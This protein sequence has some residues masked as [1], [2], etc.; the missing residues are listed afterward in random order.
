M[1]IC[2]TCGD[3]ELFYV[4]ACG[5][6]AIGESQ[7]LLYSGD[8]LTEIDSEIQT[9]DEAFDVLDAAKEQG[10]PEEVIRAQDNL[11][12][13]LDTYIK[14]GTLLP[15]KHLVQA[16]SITRRR[17]TRIRSDKMRNHWRKIPIEP[18]LRN[19]TQ[20]GQ[21]NRSGLRTAFG[22]VARKLRD[23]ISGDGI[24]FNNQVLK[25]DVAADFSDVLEADWLKWVDAVN[26]SMTYAYSDQNHDFS[27][28][29]QLLRAYAGFGVKLG[30]NPIKGTYGLSANAEAKAV[31]GEAAAV[32]EGYLPHRDGWQAMIEYGASDSSKEGRQEALD[33][34][35]FRFRIKLTANAMLG[36]SIYATAGL[37]FKPLPGTGNI[38]AQ[39]A[40]A[41][42]KGEISVG[43]FAGVE[44]GGSATG[45]LD[46][47]NPGWTEEGAVKMGPE[48]SPL[49]EIG[50]ALFG[51]AGAGFDANFKISFEG[52]RFMFRFQAQLVIGIGAKGKLNGVVGFSDILE[53]IMYVYQQLKD[54]DFSYLEFMD[55]SAFTALIGVNLYIIEHGIDAAI[56]LGNGLGFAASSAL[57][58]FNRANAAEDYATTI[59]SRPAAM[60]FA[61]PEAKGAILYKLSETYLFSFEERQEAAILTVVGTVQ[62]QREWS[63]IVER[64]SQGGR[65]TSA[66]AGLAR[67]RYILDGGSARS[68]ET[69][70][71]AIGSLPSNTMYAGT[72]VNVRNLA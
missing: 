42:G 33:F 61:S 11:A 63:L 60:I 49:L 57:A 72:P 71:R 58:P 2:A 5:D 65:K 48:W 26:D 25:G 27:A 30:H 67:L 47:K 50:G 3:F 20:D 15:E 53:F 31:L 68:F 8:E 6:A 40:S 64:I 69:I 22:D 55:E 34:G 29:A 17:W 18:S 28:G 54:N 35:Y 62:S 7:V 14:P 51:N 59:M 70:I 43:A 45:A 24:Q 56:M 4:L 1:A 9:M 44:A 16:Y 52:G 10:E 13:M 39:P 46:W 41:E 37:E 66:G 23:D 19:A 21:L 12:K 36:A 32:Y 38:Q